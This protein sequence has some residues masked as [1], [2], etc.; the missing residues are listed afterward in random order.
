MIATIILLVLIGSGLIASII[1]PV[2]LPA[3]V[4]S[5]VADFAEAF[6]SL[7]GIIPVS[8]W[9]F[10][11]SFILFITLMFAVARIIL[12][13]VALATGGGKPEV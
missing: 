6:W 5:A 9:M 4:L 3:E 13:I 2:H 7:D 11:F 10:D 12:G 8:E 1:F